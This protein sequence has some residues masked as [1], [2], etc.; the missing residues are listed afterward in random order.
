MSR[1]RRSQDNKRKENVHHHEKCR[2]ERRGN[3]ADDSCRSVKGVRPVF[4]RQDHY[5]CLNGRK[6]DHSKSGRENWAQCLPKKVRHALTIRPCRLLPFDRRCINRLLTDP[7]QGSRLAYF[8][9]HPQ[10]PHSPVDSFMNGC[11][12]DH[13][14]CET[15]G[16]PRRQ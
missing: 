1:P 15:F 11:I 6:C 10:K 16:A 9:A 4:N 5:H 13:H 14:A 8:V 3:H 7:K 2:D 12:G